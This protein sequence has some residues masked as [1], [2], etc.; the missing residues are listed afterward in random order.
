M[1]GPSGG[2]YS[3]RRLLSGRRA[4]WACLMLL[5]VIW[6]SAFAGIRIAVET[7]APVWVVAGRLWTASAFLAVWLVVEAALRRGRPV[8]D[9]PPMSAGDRRR[10]VLAFSLVGVA[11]T[12]VPFFAFAEAGR[13]ETSA[14][15]AI[16]NGATPAFTALTAWALVPGEGMG[17]QRALGVLLG[18]LGLVALVAPELRAGV[19]AASGLIFA[20]AGAAFYAG[21]NVTTRLAPRLGAVLSSFIITTTGAVATTLAAGF[22]GEPPGQGSPAS[23]AAVIALGIGPTGVATIIYVWLIQRAGPMFVALVTYLNPLWAAAVGVVFLKEPF[24]GAMAGALVL[25]L[26]G[27]AIANSGPRSAGPHRQPR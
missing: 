21:G 25:I 27:V 5:V 11:F 10:A 2:A 23:W 14:V 13:T 1:K 18:F 12:A 17:V 9:A 20:I 15:L 22:G 6:G 3:A 19:G 26:T 7:V 16:C 8:P 4:E 24:T